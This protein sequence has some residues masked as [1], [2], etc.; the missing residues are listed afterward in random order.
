MRDINKIIQEIKSTLRQAG[1][2]MRRI[3]TDV[4]KDNKQFD[5]AVVSNSNNVQMAI[6]IVHSHSSVKKHLQYCVKRGI[7]EFEVSQNNNGLRILQLKEIYEF[8]KH[9]RSNGLMLKANRLK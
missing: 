7:K 1:Q 9:R 5:V 4:H 6:N 8:V 2:N 3:R